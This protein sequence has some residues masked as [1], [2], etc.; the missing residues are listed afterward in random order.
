MRC[1]SQCIS[2]RCQVSGGWVS[3]K[4]HLRMAENSEA[5]YSSRCGWCNGQLLLPWSLPDACWPWHAPA[6]QTSQVELQAEA[7]L[8]AVLCARHCSHS[9]LQVLGQA[10]SKA[11]ILPGSTKPF[12]SFTLFPAHDPNP[13]E[14]PVWR[15]GWRSAQLNPTRPS[16]TWR[17]AAAQRAATVLT[18]GGNPQGSSARGGTL[19]WRCWCSAGGHIGC[20]PWTLVSSKAPWLPW[21]RAPCAAPSALS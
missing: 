2:L 14:L 19:P 1:S 13:R 17:A 15:L 8:H 12:P 7:D 10:H 20:W 21:P 11:S 3:L 16:T 18:P 5:A 6:A 9:W 4:A